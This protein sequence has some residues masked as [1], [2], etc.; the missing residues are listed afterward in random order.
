M[1]FECHNLSS[2]IIEEKQ[3]AHL[4]NWLK[5]VCYKYVICPSVQR[6]VN[7]QFERGIWS[8]LS[9]WQRSHD[10]RAGGFAS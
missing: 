9:G 5:K 3:N 10:D 4:T 6:E 1:Q 8:G 7:Q 2:E